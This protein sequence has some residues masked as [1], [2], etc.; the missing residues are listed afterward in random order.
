MQQ[1]LIR[2]RE[3]EAKLGNKVPDI[4]VT[5]LSDQSSKPESSKQDASTV[6]TLQAKQARTSIDLP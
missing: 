2:L 1:I 6:R 5:Y 4:K 3:V